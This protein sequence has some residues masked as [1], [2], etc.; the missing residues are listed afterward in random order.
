MSRLFVTSDLHLGHRNICKYRPQFQ[1]TQE[2]DDFIIA[3]Y[4]ETITKIDTVYFLGDIAFTDEAIER[5]KALPGHKILVLGNHDTDFG[6]A[7][8]R[9]LQE[10]FV[11]VYG[12]TSKH[13][14][15]LTHAPIHPI[16][17]RGKFCI[18]GHV[19]DQTIQDPRYANVCVENTNYKPVLLT[20]VKESLLA[21]KIFK[22][23]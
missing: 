8:S 21:G 1:T 7:R 10:A 9:S 15:W 2:H 3:N 16:E 23:N 18:H 11:R 6:M 14:C 22:G 20:K 5:V 12:I 13:H 4:L 19:H 17:L